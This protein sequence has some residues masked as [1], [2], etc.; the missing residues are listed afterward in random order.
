MLLAKIQE[1]IEIMATEKVNWYQY[2]LPFSMNFVWK[3]KR[4]R[5]KPKIGVIKSKTLVVATN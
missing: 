3:M 5:S 2:L 4:Q 1:H